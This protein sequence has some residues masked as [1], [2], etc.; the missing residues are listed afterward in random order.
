MPLWQRHPLQAGLSCLPSLQALPV[1]GR[2][3]RALPLVMAPRW[4]LTGHV[5]SARRLPSTSS[6]FAPR[7]LA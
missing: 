1:Q 7:E 2:S 3:G 5:T 4:E 6:P